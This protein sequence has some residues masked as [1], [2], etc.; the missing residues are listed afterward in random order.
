MTLLTLAFVT[1]VLINKKA[2]AKQRP[3]DY[4]PLA[5]WVLLDVLFA[6]GTATQQLWPAVIYC[7]VLGAI[8]SVAAVRGGRW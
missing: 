5:V 2:S 3:P 1:P 8:V 4:H 7:A 6:V